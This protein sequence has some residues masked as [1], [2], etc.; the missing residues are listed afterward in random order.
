MELADLHSA[1]PYLLAR[2]QRTLHIKI[3]ISD[4]ATLS[5]EKAGSHEAEV[6]DSKGFFSFYW[7]SSQGNY[8]KFR[9]YSGTCGSLNEFPSVYPPPKKYRVVQ[10]SGFYCV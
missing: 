3:F 8:K 6:G 1:Q 4:N 2:P 5:M 9:I 7:G 10:Y